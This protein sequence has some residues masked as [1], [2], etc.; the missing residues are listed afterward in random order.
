MHTFLFCLNLINLII[1]MQFINV[2][3]AF[4]IV[5]DKARLKKSESIL[6]ASE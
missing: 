6:P 4:E 2:K 1:Q 3:T 5:K